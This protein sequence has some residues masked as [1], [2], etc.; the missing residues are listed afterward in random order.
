LFSG[1][2]RVLL[3]V[4]GGMDSM[5]MAEL[6]SLSGF[7][8]AMVHCNFKLRAS[9]ADADE[10]FVRQAAE[11]YGVE[12]HVRS[13]NTSEISEDTG[14]SVQMIA[15]DLR[16]TYFEEI[17]VQHGYDH[18]ATAHHLDDQIETF[19]IN[20]TR[21]CGIGGLH[22][23]PV[24]K[25][26]II[27]PM[28]FAHRKDIET[29]VDD[30]KLTY[31][32]DFSNK[33][34]KYLRNKIR[35]ELM[36]LFLEINPS[37]A[38]EMGA[39]INRLSETEDIFKQF[40]AQK[41]AEVSNQDGGV[42]SIDIDQLRELQPMPTFLYEFISE[43]GFKEAD[44]SNIINALDGISGKKFLSPTH[45]LIIDR[46]M[47]LISSLQNDKQDEDLFIAKEISIVDKPL[48]L[49]FE[50]HP[51]VEY[52]IPTDKNIASLDL[53]KLSFPLLLRKWKQGDA[54]I[55][56]GM[57]NHKKLSDFFIDE[58][59]SLFDKEETWVICSGDEI[60]WIVGHRIDDRYKITIDSRKILQIRH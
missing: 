25:G 38:E 55:P 37:F 51:A 6:F 39:N 49:I 29:F 44:V 40:V 59:F 28:L 22:G 10:V 26:K 34:S 13:F 18:I 9:E 19:F 32:E 21:G 43:Y 20:L 45:Q 33:S 35:N 58:K 60:V 48:K 41:R 3:A 14:H 56:L 30:H 11:K 16:Y 23:I 54:F 1:P 46:K 2:D 15:R 52:S 50:K 36:P 4:S 8:F 47:I 24:R 53:D 12:C 31:R 42:V 57:N 17:A 27:R 5:T 7:N